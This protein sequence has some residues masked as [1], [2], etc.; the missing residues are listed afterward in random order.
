MNT[1][2]IRMTLDAYSKLQNTFSEEDSY[3]VFGPTA[4]FNIWQKFEANNNQFP[5]WMLGETEGRKLAEYL[6]GCIEVESLS[7]VSAQV[8]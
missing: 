1:D 8:G 3:A 7:T 2:D 4:G 6:S 5:L